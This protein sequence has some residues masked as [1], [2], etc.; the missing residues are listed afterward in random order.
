M[1]QALTIPVLVLGTTGFLLAA[2]VVALDA[3]VASRIPSDDLISAVDDL[4]PQTQCAQCGYPGC[5]PYAN[6]VV[7]G[8]STA[9]CVPGGEE[10]HQALA[11]LLDR[12]EDNATLA[13]PL[14]LTA[15]IQEEECVGC[16]LCL[17]ACPVDAI[18]GAPQFLHT[19]LESHCTG[20]ELCVSPCP[21]SC[22]ELVE[23]S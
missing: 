8:E 6:A 19:V 2:V 11:K 1:I 7:N 21:V 15:R 10:T 5:R 23:P 20:C 16:G 9:L 4:L 18:I 3:I 13:E 17:D 22:I 14:E 12:P